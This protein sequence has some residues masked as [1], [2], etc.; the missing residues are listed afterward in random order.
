MQLTSILSAA[1]MAMTVA[2]A[3]AEVVARNG[4]G[5]SSS[6]CNAGS[7]VAC[8]TPVAGGILG[9]NVL[10]CLVGV[11]TCNGGSAQCCKTSASVSVCNDIPRS[12]SL[13]S[14]IFNR[15]PSRSFRAT[16]L[17]CKGLGLTSNCHATP[18]AGAG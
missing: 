8:C 13:C 16:V 6:Q 11:L 10:N 2:A 17:L 14:Q 4:Q 9:L 1:A 12:S 3:P 5:G 15:A 18:V 7:T